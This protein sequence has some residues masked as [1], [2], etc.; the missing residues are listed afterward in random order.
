[1]LEIIS[2]TKKFGSFTAVENL[3]IKVDIG[4]IYGFLGPNGAGKT[5]TIKMIATLLKP[6]AGSVKIDG[7]DAHSSPT[8]A[9]KYL[10]YV[11]D[12]PFLY[13]KLSGHEFLLFTARMYGMSDKESSDG[14][15][16]VSEIY[17]VKP[18]L[19]KRIEDYSQ[20]MRQRLVLAAAMMHRPKLIVIDEPMVGLD[21]RGAETFKS[22]IKLAAQ[23]GTAVFL[24]THQL[25]LAK[26]V[27]T[28]IGI[29]HSGKLVFDGGMDQFSTDGV[30]Y[31]EEKYIE[32]T[33]NLQ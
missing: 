33:A 25:S 12:Q 32:L 27:C 5:T 9:K 15:R 7:I 18:W 1:M 4:E 16:N 30:G 21:P 13:E 23:D 31:L 2:L 28:R 17:E 24:T 26:D 3:S 14:I 6:T 19:N 10:S 22:Q 8:E 29:I 11:P 20:G